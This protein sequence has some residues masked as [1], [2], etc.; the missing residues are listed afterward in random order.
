MAT[1]EVTIPIYY[2]RKQPYAIEESCSRLNE[3]KQNYRAALANQ[4][5]VIQR[6]LSK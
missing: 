5:G 3:A 4:C 1:V 6:T 2:A